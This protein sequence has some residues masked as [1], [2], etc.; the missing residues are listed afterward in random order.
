L[1]IALIKLN[2]ILT[3]IN[4]KIFYELKESLKISVNKIKKEH[5]K[6]KEEYNLFYLYTIYI[7]N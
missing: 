3:K 4:F 1:L 2:I 5:Y 7:F 6:N